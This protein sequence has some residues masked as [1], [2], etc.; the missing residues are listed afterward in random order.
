MSSHQCPD[1]AVAV[2]PVAATA[3]IRGGRIVLLCRGCFENRHQT[4]SVETHRE[5]EQTGDNSSQHFS[6]PLQ[7]EHPQEHSTEISSHITDGE[8]LE[9]KREENDHHEQDDQPLRV[10]LTHDEDVTGEI[11]LEHTDTSTKTPTNTSTKTP[12]NLHWNQ[13]YTIG[14][15]VTALALVS[16]FAFTRH[17]QTS[18]LPS[19]IPEASTI[20]P[21]TSA[22][23]RHMT[24]EPPEAA[25]IHD[26]S[27][28]FSE[29]QARLQWI[30][31]LAVTRQLPNKNDRRFGA[32]RP[33]DRPAECLGGH[34]GVD[35]GGVRGATVHAALGGRLIRVKRDPS[36]RA[37]KYVAIEHP[38]GM[39]SYYMHMDRIHPDLVEGMDVASGEPIGTLGSTGVHRSPPHLHFSVQARR[40]EGG[41]H[42][43]DPEPMLKQATVLIAN[44]RVPDRAPIVANR[45][46]DPW[47]FSSNGQPSHRK[48]HPISYA[49]DKNIPSDAELGIVIDRGEISLSDPRDDAEGNDVIVD[50]GDIIDSGDSLIDA[51]AHSPPKHALREVSIKQGVVDDEKA[52]A[53]GAEPT[54]RKRKKSKKSSKSDSSSTPTTDDGQK[55]P[56]KTTP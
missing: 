19:P 24:F 9:Q 18:R 22:H 41:W 8:T 30:H 32:D 35:L 14:M 50:T 40:Q 10:A 15:A 55:V 34:C 37:G 43:V 52:Q 56:S 2:S 31:P 28:A 53:K 11:V 48:G 39:R 21:E 29:A 4:K 27:V 23:L 7:S 33:G 1:C 44:G 5:T 42:Y 47:L 13:G 12:S 25:V 45:V 54:D 20:G 16:T 6:Q 46:R 36:G 26:L 17:R 51:P 3:I 38:Q 49:T